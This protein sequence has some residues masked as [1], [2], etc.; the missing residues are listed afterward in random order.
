[1]KKKR[2][3][4]NLIDKAIALFS[5]LVIFIL[6]SA[7]SICVFSK[8]S[9][10]DIFTSGRITELDN[11]PKQFEKDIV[12]NAAHLGKIGGVWTLTN[13]LLTEIAKKKPNWRFVVAIHEKLRKD[14]QIPLPNI[15]HVYVSMNYTDPMEYFYKFLNWITRNRYHD[16]LLQLCFYDKIFLDSKCDL[17][18]DPS[19]E[20]T[21]NGFSIPSVATIH[22]LALFDIHESYVVADHISWG[23]RRIT[24]AALSSKKIITVSEFS[25]RRIIEKFG[26]PWNSV[27]VIPI[28][29]GKRVFNFVDQGSTQSVLKNYNLQDKSYLIF[30]SGFWPNKNHERLIRAF[31]QFLQKEKTSNLK[32]VLCGAKAPK[33]LFALT[34]QLGIKERVIFTGFVSDKD[35]SVL[36]QHALAFVHSSVYEGFGMPIIE[37]MA[38]GIPVASSDAGSLPEVAGGAALMFNPYDVS[39][40]VSAISKIVHDASLREHLISLGKE[41][42]KVFEDT[43]K[44][45]DAYIKVFEDTMDKKQIQEWKFQ[46]YSAQKIVA[47]KLWQVR[48]C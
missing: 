6:V 8:S 21:I 14:Y 16:K 24:A 1:M 40:I 7:V 12:V 38:A 37:A 25:K 33:E 43:D 35:L 27:E 39:S 29:L 44:M 17:I 46:G 41:R 10:H 9:W 30:V 34:K 22:D 3:L 13:N 31:N 45:I 47:E 42:A 5:A 48:I 15:K 2:E 18:W 32:L 4:N 23:R 19:G 20:D 28:Q 36:L 11:R 26:L